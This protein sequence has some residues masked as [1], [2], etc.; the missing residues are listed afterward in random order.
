VSICKKHLA[1]GYKGIPY[2]KFKTLVFFAVGICKDVDS[3]NITADIS[4]FALKRN[5]RK[6]KGKYYRNA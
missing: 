3:E 2:L 4:A 6:H 1:F 5:E